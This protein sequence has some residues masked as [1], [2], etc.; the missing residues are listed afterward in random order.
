M[1]SVETIIYYHQA[2]HCFVQFDQDGHLVSVFGQKGVDGTSLH[3]K[4]EV[5]LVIKSVINGGD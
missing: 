2:S 5:S 4:D 3:T 1:W